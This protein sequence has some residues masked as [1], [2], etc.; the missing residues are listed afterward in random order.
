M[1]GTAAQTD[2][3][4]QVREG[5]NQVTAELVAWSLE[6]AASGKYP[7]S[8]FRGRPFE[9][10]TYRAALAGQPLAGEYRSLTQCSVRF[11]GGVLVWVSDKVE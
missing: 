5:V 4:S 7:T 11:S 3:R 1:L 10:G 8:G 6:C 9:K 2:R